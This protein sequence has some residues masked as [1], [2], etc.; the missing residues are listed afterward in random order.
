MYRFVTTI[1]RNDRAYHNALHHI[2]KA[3]PSVVPKVWQYLVRVLSYLVVV[4]YLLPLCIV[5]AVLLDPV[6]GS[7]GTTVIFRTC[8]FSVLPG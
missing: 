3:V 5:A 1:E 2:H 4:W 6:P 8:L 7:H